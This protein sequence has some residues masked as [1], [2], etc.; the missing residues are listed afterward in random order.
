[1][2]VEVTRRTALQG[3]ATAVGGRRLG[4]SASR[5]ITVA[6]R[7]LYLGA[8]LFR[9]LGDP[10]ESAAAVVGSLLERVDESAVERRMDAVA[11]ELAAARPDV[12]G[13]QEVAHVRTERPSDGTPEDGPDATTTRYDFLALLRDALADRGLAYDVAAVSRNTDAEFPA[14]VDDERVDVRLTDRDALLVRAETTDVAAA[15]AVTFDA[16]LTLPVGDGFTLTRGYAAADLRVG[17]R[18]LTAA[19]THLEPAAAETRTAQATELRS[20]LADPPTAVV[21]GDLND[22]PAGGSGAYEVLTDVFADAHAVVHPD[23]VGGAPTCCFRP[24]LR[25]GDAETALTDRYD[26]VLARGLATTAARRVGVDPNARVDSENDLLW[27]SDHAG[28]VATFEGGSD[29]TT[30]GSGTGT[31]TNTRTNTPTRTRTE[32]AAPSATT[33]PSPTAGDATPREAPATGTTETTGPGFGALAAV[34]G[35]LAAGVRFAIRPGER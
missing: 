26:I 21:L 10:E 11:A 2:A 15:R 32:P 5:P 6:T 22:G 16:T 7:N 19:S 29:A 20:A 4:S 28:V 12:V 31:S 9:L 27:P 13:L 8:D 35:A 23:A 3:V 30:T 18:S 33:D 24:S 17:D 1:M 25:T 34:G 14:H